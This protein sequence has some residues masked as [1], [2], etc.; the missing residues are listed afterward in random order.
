MVYMTEMMGNVARDKED[1]KIGVKQKNG[2][3]I[4]I[5]MGN[6]SQDCEMRLGKGFGSFRAA[7]PTICS[8]Q[9]RVQP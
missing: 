1:A 2:C 4:K 5:G 6:S 9:F 7:K 3:V 8:E